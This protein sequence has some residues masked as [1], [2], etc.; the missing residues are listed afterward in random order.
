M[1]NP[2][3][4]RKNLEG[5]APFDIERDVESLTPLNTDDALRSSVGRLLVQQGIIAEGLLLI[6]NKL[7]EIQG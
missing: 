7:D 1:H 2:E 6:L 5:I 3:Y 4:V